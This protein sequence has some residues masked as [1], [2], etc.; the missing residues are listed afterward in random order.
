MS[1]HPNL[2]GGYVA[3]PKASAA[4]WG[5]ILASLRILARG[6]SKAF[7]REALDVL[8]NVAALALFL[9]AVAIWAL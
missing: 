9:G 4:P 7:R 8:A 5:L 1:Y 3:R 2:A 6:P